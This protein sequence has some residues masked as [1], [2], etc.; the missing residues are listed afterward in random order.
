MLERAE[1][2]GDVALARAVACRAIDRGWR[3]VVDSYGHPNPE[4]GEAAKDLSAA[5]LSIGLGSAIVFGVPRPPELGNIADSDVEKIV[6]ANEPLYDR[7]GKLADND[8]G[9]L[10]E[11]G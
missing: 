7:L 8:P 5:R 11:T 1:R 9:S 10:G 6:K 3:S 2:S 4:W